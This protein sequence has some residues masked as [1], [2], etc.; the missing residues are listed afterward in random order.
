VIAPDLFRCPTT[1]QDLHFREC[2]DAA[3][4]FSGWQSFS[5][6]YALGELVGTL[7]TI[8]AAVAYPVWK[9]VYGLLPELAKFAEATQVAAALS[10]TKRSVARFYDD[11]GWVAGD[12][13]EYFNDA[14]AFEDLRPLTAFYRTRCHR[15]VNKALGAGKYLLDVASGAVQIPEYVSFSA[16]YEKRICVDISVKGLL[17]AKRRLRDH[18]ICVIGDI[19]ALPLRNN[20]VDGFVSLHTVYHVPADEQSNAVAELF[21]TLRPGGR[22]VIVYSWGATA[23]IYR[24]IVNL[25]RWLRR[26]ARSSG[27]AA[28]PADLYFNPHDY[29]WYRR[30]V[31]AKYPVKLRIWR[32]LEKESLEYVA[33]G[34]ISAALV[35][36]PL[37]LLEQTFPRF[38]GRIGICP[39]FVFAKPAS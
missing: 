35:L 17:H 28:P 6:R 11:Y 5:A 7:E 33:R 18:A 20:I 34:K 38:F 23:K 26:P 22:G 9:D 13:D 27:T 16:P 14:L 8:D 31:A 10:D 36:W 3:R 30:E 29:G 25:Q 32:S 15:R 39:M 12:G 21:R 2:S 37:Y 19:T 24:A 1:K 4:N